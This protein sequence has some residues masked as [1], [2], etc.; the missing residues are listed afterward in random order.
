MGTTAPTPG[1]TWRR[2]MGPSGADP[3]AQCELIRN[4]DPGIVAQL[5]NGLRIE[6]LKD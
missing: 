5:E 6:L 3:A 2:P 1:V 4:S